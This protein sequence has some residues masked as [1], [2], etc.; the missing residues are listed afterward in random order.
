MSEKKFIEELRKEII[1]QGG[2]LYEISFI[3]SEL[4]KNAIANNRSPKDVAW[5]LIQ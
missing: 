5:A 3:T 2:S 4:V 1:L